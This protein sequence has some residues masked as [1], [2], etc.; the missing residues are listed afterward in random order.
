ML[1][2]GPS[3]AQPLFQTIDVPVMHCDQLSESVHVRPEYSGGFKTSGL[4][5]CWLIGFSKRSLYQSRCF[6][7]FARIFLMRSI[8]SCGF[9]LTP[10]WLPVATPSSALW[11]HSFE[12]SLRHLLSVP[13]PR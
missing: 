10:Q 12:F 8:S 11:S 5:F 2:R 13:I 1:S 7:A 9:I 6:I 3:R 4:P